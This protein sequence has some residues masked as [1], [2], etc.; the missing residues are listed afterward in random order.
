LLN[1]RVYILI[2][3]KIMI[4]MAARVDLLNKK[5]RELEG[6]SPD[7]EGAAVAS[8][9]GFIMAS[10]LPAG[11]D[12]ELVAAMSALMVSTAERNTK[13]LD[14]GELNEVYVRG[15]EGYLLMRGIGENAVLVTLAR[16]DAK[17]GLVFLDMRRAAD[18]IKD[19][20]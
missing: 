20:V 5:L 7:I 3:H 6:T 17:L 15:S 9:E 14:R 13:E 4:V 12:E 8:S 11:T 2:A 18:E 19:L 10:A 1:G 16:K